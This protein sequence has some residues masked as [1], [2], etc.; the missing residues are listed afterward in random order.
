MARSRVARQLKRTVGP[1]TGGPENEEG[2]LVSRVALQS[3]AWVRRYVL[4]E[5]PRVP[6]SRPSAIN[7]RTCAF[8]HDFVIEHAAAQPAGWV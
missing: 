1:G 7:P 5:P 6:L 4:W 3:V 2:H 8:D